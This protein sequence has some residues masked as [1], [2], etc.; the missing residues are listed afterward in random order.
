MKA[1]PSDR[2]RRLR[3][4]SPGLAWLV[5]PLALALSVCL[6]AGL[7]TATAATPTT[8]TATTAGTTTDPTAPSPESTSLRVSSFNVLGA[9]HTGTGG[10]KR[11]YA[12]GEQRMKWAVQLIQKYSLDVIGMQEFQPIQYDTFEQLVGDR[13][14]VYPGNQLTRAAMANSIA[15]RLSQ[16][17]LVKARTVRI[18]YFDGTMIKMPYVLLRSVQTGR[19][20]WFFNTHNPADAR[21]PAQKWRNQGFRIERNLVKNLRT[22]NPEIPVFVTGDKNDTY[23]YFCPQKR[24]SELQAAN[25]AT[26]TSSTCALP[27]PRIVDWVMGTS[28]V[29][30]SGYHAIRN[31]LVKK[32]T[33]H[34]LVFSDAYIPSEE[35]ARSGID[36]VVLI[37]VDGLRSDVVD[38]ARTDALHRMMADGAWTP[39]ARTDFNTVDRLGNAVGMLTGLRVDPDQG[40]HGAG[41]GQSTPTTIAQSAGRYVSSVLGT[42]H[43]FGRGTALVTDFPEMKLVRDSWSASTGAADPYMPD[44]GRNKLSRFISVSK[45]RSVAMQARD[46][47]STSSPAFLQVQ[48]SWPGNAGARSGWRSDAYLNAVAATDRRIGSIVRAINASPSFAGRTVVVVTAPRGGN[49]RTTRL[50]TR[51]GWY[52]VPMFVTGPGVP[53][54]ADLYALNPQLTDPGSGRPNYS[55]AAQPIRTSDIA[56]LVTRLL[57]Q[58]AVPGSVLDADQSF[59]VFGA[60]PGT[61]TP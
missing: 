39:N 32:T 14:G 43:D 19:E 36:H 12:S 28:D 29:R 17:Q 24:Q 15:W 21:G 27:Q 44:N 40:G 50:A 53:A 60:A 2:A 30:F 1:K 58:P 6:P 10:N 56:N 45:D 38:R 31:W 23:Q 20:V 33:D 42:T 11:G 54:G 35:S 55:A 51:V 34:H 46:L 16:W 61:T 26:A 3:P 25:G 57:G 22:N 4:R 5:A 8:A 52:R 49:G 48:F 18:P 7:V 59:T 47:I 9:G 13:F 37:S 41:W